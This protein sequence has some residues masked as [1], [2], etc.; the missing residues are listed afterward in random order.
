MRVF[1]AAW[2]DTP[3][4]HFRVP[5]YLALLLVLVEAG[6]EWR[7]HERGYTTLFFGQ[8]ETASRRNPDF[9][10]RSLPVPAERRPGS[11]RI[12]LSSASH[13]EDNYQPVD[14]IFPTRLCALLEQ[15]GQACDMLNA[16]RA[17]VGIADNTQELRREAGHWRPDIAVLYQAKIDIDELSKT[18]FGPPAPKGEIAEPLPHQRALAHLR[19]VFEATT[20]Y[21]HLT[22][23]L[24]TRMMQARVLQPAL[25]VQA[26]AEYAARVRR[27]IATSREQGIRPVLTTFAVRYGTRDAEQ[28]SGELERSLLQ[29]NPYLSKAG[30]LRSIA[31]CNEILREIAEEEKVQLIDLAGPV[32]GQAALFRD[33]SH[34]S[35]AGHER[36]AELL[37]AGLKSPPSLSAR[38]EAAR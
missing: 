30:W 23:Q 18:S 12:W 28:F 2:R 31:R 21:A 27:F 38:K 20:L 3:L 25:P 5:L 36:M 34:F 16:S 13:A 11:L 32:S 37:A 24:K 19:Q 35:V 14:K 10:F 17:G 29:Y 15:S 26:E 6:F 33:F 1:S 7:A 9:P 8:H 4:A 22:Q